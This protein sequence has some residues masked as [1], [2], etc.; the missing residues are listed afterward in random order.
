MRREPRLEKTLENRFVA[1]MTECGYMNIKGDM[2]A[3]KNAG[4]TDRIFFGH[5]PRTIVVEFKRERVKKNRHERLQEH[6]RDEFRRR[7]YEVYKVRGR[8]ETER[9]FRSIT[10]RSLYAEKAQILPAER[11]RG[12]RRRRRSRVG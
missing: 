9:L 6:T 11:A 4:M 1:G 5:G 8:D 2:A 10:G 7:G 3:E 12:D